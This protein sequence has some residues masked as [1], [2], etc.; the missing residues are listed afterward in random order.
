MKRCFALLLALLT[1]ALYSCNDK[2]APFENESSSNGASTNETFPFE[3]PDDYVFIT[4]DTYSQCFAEDDKYYY[5]NY[6]QVDP[7]E[8]IGLIYFAKQNKRT[9][10][11]TIIDTLICGFSKIISGNIYYRKNNDF[12]IYKYNTRNET[13]SNMTL[14]DIRPKDKIENDPDFNLLNPSETETRITTDGFYFYVYGDKSILYKTN[15]KLQITEKIFVSDISLMEAYKNYI[16]YD[17]DGKLFIYSVKD[18]TSRLLFEF[19]A[20]ETIRYF[21]VI[22]NNYI[23]VDS[24]IKETSMH[25]SYI[26]NLKKRKIEKEIDNGIRGFVYNDESI[27]GII[28][29]SI[30]KISCLNFSTEKI[31]ELS[32][33]NSTYDLTYLTFEKDRIYF[34]I[35][36]GNT[37]AHKLISIDKNG[38]EEKIIVDK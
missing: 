2:T 33:N 15:D 23:V 7:G 14:T 13:I 3:F 36:D 10:E 8:Y 22:G 1:L 19:E 29:K 9:S 11:I 30:L 25:K 16:L 4:E 20:G 5:F 28:N 27:Y 26:F 35:R 38:N 17:L 32:S 6:G 31:Y 37:E 12:T 24:I 18:K 34:D 21:G